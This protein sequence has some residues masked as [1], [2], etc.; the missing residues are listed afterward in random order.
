MHLFG[1]NTGPHLAHFHVWHRGGSI[2][3][4]WEVRNSPPLRWRVLRSERD[5]ASSADPAA[6]EGQLL[7][8][9]GAET[10]VIDQDVVAGTHYF[11]TVFAQDE[12]GSWHRQVHAKVAPKAKLSW[13]H[14]DLKT[15]TKD[16][17]DADD[18]ADD[19]GFVLCLGTPRFRSDY[20]DRH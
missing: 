15:V 16:E 11:Y 12:S 6:E 17:T 4:E 13:H 19:L 7:L 2:E 20:F 10:H 3:L 8:M 5:F 9:E 1:S 14:E 18:R